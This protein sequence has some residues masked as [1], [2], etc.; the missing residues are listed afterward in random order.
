MGQILRAFNDKNHIFHGLLC[1]Y[2][3]S[4]FQARHAQPL[5]YT[6]NIASDFT[7]VYCRAAGTIFGTTGVYELGF[8]YLSISIFSLHWYNHV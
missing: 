4:K 6:A 7:C 3:G 5:L 2:F 8:S 1:M